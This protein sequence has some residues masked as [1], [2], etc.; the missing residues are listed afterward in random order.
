MKFLLINGPN[1]SLLNKRESSFYGTFT[2]ESIVE[3]LK[4]EFPT[5]T[6]VNV[7]LSSEAEI[8]DKIQDSSTIYDGIILN[9]GGLS[10]TAVA[11]R[12]CIEI[13]DIPL[14]EVHLSNISS[15]ESF[16]HLSLTASKAKGYISGFKK[17]SYFGAVYLLKKIANSSI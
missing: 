13:A 6:F 15:R 5:D 1:L 11:L 12:D 2:I 9:P 14:I 7:Y 3:E 10:H 8:I 4:I 17:Y 16:R